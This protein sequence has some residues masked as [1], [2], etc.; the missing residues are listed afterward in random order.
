MIAAERYVRESI[1]CMTSP[2][3]IGQE[4][5]PLNHSKRDLG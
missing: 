1:I 3:W 4:V 5:I 2:V